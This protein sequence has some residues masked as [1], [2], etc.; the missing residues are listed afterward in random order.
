MPWLVVEG[1][2]SWSPDLGREWIDDDSRFPPAFAPLDDAGNPKRGFWRARGGVFK[3][4]AH[5]VS[6]EVANKA[7]DSGYPWLIVMPDEDKPVVIETELSGTLEPSDLKE[8][9]GGGVRLLRVIEGGD[10]GEPQPDPEPVF[11][12]ECRWCLTI[13]RP[14][15]P[16]SSALD[17]H[18]EF[19]HPVQFVMGTE[20][21]LEAAEAIAREREE[22][23][24]VADAGKPVP[25]WEREAVTAAGLPSPP[26][27][28]PTIP[29]AS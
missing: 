5:Q 17:R 18:V 3:A 14:T 13:P 25:V 7:L 12:H 20:R 6:E 23:R 28:E 4:G 29:Q 16:S 2:G 15:F 11:E 8:A 22:L 26:E 10:T 1:K 9:K 19:A 27:P 21:A 24:R